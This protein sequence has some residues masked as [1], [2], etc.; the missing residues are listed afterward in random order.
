MR[1]SR[2]LRIVEIQPEIFALRPKS[3]LSAVYPLRSFIR[4][5]VKWLQWV[6]EESGESPKEEGSKLTA[7]EISGTGLV[8]PCSEKTAHA[9]DL[10]IDRRGSVFERCGV[11]DRKRGSSRFDRIPTR[12][13]TMSCLVAGVWTSE[14]AVGF[15]GSIHSEST[16]ASG[17]RLFDAHAQ[18]M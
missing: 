3:K 17:M 16:L 2:T 12:I 18:S 15:A 8:K 6:D 11:N 1:I 4:P 9:A 7:S 10:M 13:P 14:D 5:V